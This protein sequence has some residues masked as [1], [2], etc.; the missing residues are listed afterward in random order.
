[1]PLP[2]SLRELPREVWVLASVA[3]AVAVGFGIVAPAI[4]L[5]AKSFGVDNTH[6]ASVISAF[7][8]MRLLTAPIGG[9]VVD[10]FGERLVMATGV[11]IVAVSSAVAGL[12][13]TYTQLLVLRGVGGFGSALFTVSAATLLLRSV[14][15]ELRGRASGMFSGGFLFGGISGPALGGFVTGISRRLPFFLY[16][17]TLAVAVTIALIALRHSHTANADAAAR[18]QIERTAVFPLFRNASYRAALATNFADAWAMLGVRS[19]LI[20]IFV[21]EVLHKSSSWTGAGFVVVAAINASLL[22]P[23]GKFADTVG[24]RPVLIAGC[25]AGAASLVVLALVPNL[26]GYLIAMALLGFGS[27]LLDVAPAAMAGDVAGRRGGSAIAAYQMSGD[28]G[29]IVGPLIVG[30]LADHVS[31]G[32]G[33]LVTAGV[34][35]AAAVL[36]VVAPETHHRVT[37]A[38]QPE[39]EAERYGA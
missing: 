34:L 36:A 12:S 6:A 9:R 13:Q 14:P 3:F 23:A 37:T 19:A 32:A 39:A 20:P 24:R 5:F 2:A 18:R 21:T 38:P 26:P 10:R 1:M 28:L 15:N 27:G 33:F 7:A 8:F 4:P 22:L 29:M 11:G 17:G 35:G 30:Y 25:T 16:A 31:Y